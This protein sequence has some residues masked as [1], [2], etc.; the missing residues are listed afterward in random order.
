MMNFV[1]TINSS[2]IIL[3]EG[4]VIERL[5]RDP[6]IDLDPYILNAGLIYDDTGRQALERIYRQYIEIGLKY[7]I[8]LLLA[9]PTWRANPD[10]IKASRS[11]MASSSWT[12]Q[13][14]K[15]LQRS[16]WLCTINS[17]SR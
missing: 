7:K 16:C 10:R 12:V 9:A 4:A 15:A 8:P 11:W 1:E 2:P 6:S 13:T 5:H 17:E 14:P 3:T